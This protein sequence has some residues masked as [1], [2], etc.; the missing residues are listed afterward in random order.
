MQYIIVGNGVASV[1]A[2][3]G[4]RSRDEQ[5]TITIVSREGDKTYGRPLISHYLAGN[6]PEKRMLLRPDGFYERNNVQ[7]Q[8]DRDVESIDCS[9]KIISSDKGDLEYDRLLLATGGNPIFPPIEGATGP[10]VY[11]FISLDDAR[12]VNSVVKDMRRAVVI[13]GGL[14][15]LKASEALF[16]RGV[17]VTVVEL[18]SRILS[19][20]FDDIAG[21]IVSER[22]QNMGFDIRC[23]TTVNKI[24]RGDDNRVKGVFLQDGVFLEADAV[25]VA[26]G[27]VPSIEL[28]QRAGLNTNRGIVVDEKLQT[29]AEN[30]YAAGD[31][32]EAVD[33]LWEDNRVTPIWPNAYAQGLYAGRNMAAG[34]E[35]EEEYEG[36]LAMNSIEFYGLPT[37]SIGIV[38]PPE[39]SSFEV[40][41]NLDESRSRYRKLIFSEDRLVGCVLVGDISLAGRYNA[42]IRFKIKLDSKTKSRLIAGNPTSLQWPEKKFRQ[43]WNKRARLA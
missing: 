26:I 27:V 6:V 10:D 42:F 43:E 39:S 30:V 18:S 8:L 2:V 36:G 38:N 23:S 21:N 7:L 28:A 29:S 1:G 3:E 11:T 25:V 34:M 17:D 31:V 33:L 13:G 15:G 9:Q 14:I 20:A 12:K 22:L 41:A 35:G 32:A 16:D 19:A 4:I 40:K 37:V 5:G 24:K